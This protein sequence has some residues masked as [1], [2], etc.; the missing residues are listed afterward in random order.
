MG[1]IIFGASGAGFTTL[2]RE[3]AGR[4]KYQYLD[5]GDYLWCWNT[6][7]HSDKNR[8]KSM[9]C[10]CYVCQENLNESTSYE[11]IIPNAI[12][13]FIK[14]RELICNHCNKKFGD[15]IDFE[16][17][18]QLLFVSNMLGIRRD[19]GQSP[20]FPTSDGK[21]YISSDGEFIRHKPDI[22]ERAINVT[23]GAAEVKIDVSSSKIESQM[24]SIAKELRQKGVPEESVMEVLNKMK[25][26]ID[27]YWESTKTAISFEIGGDGLRAIAKIAASFY[28]FNGGEHKYVQQLIPTL[29][30]RC[31][32]ER[33]NVYY[34]SKNV[35]SKDDEEVLHSVIVIGDDV[36]KVLYAYVELFNFYKCIVL[37]SDAY[38][39]DY[40]Y[41]T[42]FLDVL[43]SPNTVERDHTLKLSREKLIGI[44]NESEF[45]QK[46]Y[47]EALRQILLLA[48]SKKR[49]EQIGN[50][51]ENSF[52]K[53]PTGVPMT[54]EMFNAFMGEFIP[55]I[56]AQIPLEENKYQ[57]DGHV[58]GLI[59]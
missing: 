22:R 1:I 10:K 9:N 43:N 20:S 19:R 45:P 32:P 7:Y 54:Q 18:K 37:L 52:G 47:G 31:R 53:F 13:G 41:A 30:C 59:E 8:G 44:V 25:G 34:P 29:L 3:I 48:D 50:I 5:I 49:S 23:N 39:G 14:S 51:I 57:V 55:Y 26:S 2:G 58:S 28:I 24:K 15:G 27:H 4:L 46:H 33:V 17:S 40:F 11:H 56:I 35:V 6:K 16:L 42:H 21:G 38:E 12:G 36:E